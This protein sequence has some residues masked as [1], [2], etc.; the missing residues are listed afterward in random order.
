[1]STKPTRTREELT[2]LITEWLKSRPKCVSVTGV[3]VAPM[4]RISADGPNWHAAFTIAES[5]PVPDTA[6]Q[7]VD[8]ITLQF[9]LA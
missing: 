7:F 8:D 2:A 1:M 6:L 9:D 4:V 3:A 5:G